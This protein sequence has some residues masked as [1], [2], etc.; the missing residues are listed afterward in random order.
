MR[1]RAAM[2]KPDQ[3]RRERVLLSRFTVTPVN[4]ASRRGTANQDCS[5]CD[6]LKAEIQLWHNQQRLHQ[7]IIAELAGVQAK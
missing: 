5:F 7:S 6:E 2:K 1:N 4:T 3:R